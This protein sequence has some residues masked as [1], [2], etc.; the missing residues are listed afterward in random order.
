MRYGRIDLLETCR[1][2]DSKKGETVPKLFLIAIATTTA[3]AGQ[4]TRAEASM[5]RSGSKTQCFPTGNC[6]DD[7]AS[8]YTASGRI[9]YTNAGA[10][11]ITG[12]VM[13]ADGSLSVWL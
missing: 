9:A 3:F 13:Q 11:G 5:S 4:I 6:D 8:G 7:W 10:A 2:A 12:D 1:S